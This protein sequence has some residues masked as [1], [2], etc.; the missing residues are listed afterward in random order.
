MRTAAALSLIVLGSCCLAA[1]KAQA[2]ETERVVLV[3]IDGLRYSEGL[4]DAA[5]EYTPKMHDLAQQGSIVEP[6]RNDGY[7]WTSRAIPAIWC[8]AWT[9]VLPFDDPACGGQENSYSELPTG[10]EYFRKQLNE[11]AMSC[12]YV[13]KDVGCPWRA[14]FHP[15]Y[16]PDWWPLYDS[17]GSDDLDVW[18]ETLNVLT[19]YS[20]KFLLVYLAEVDHAG[21]SGNWQTYV[22]AIAT[23]DSI[24][25]MIWTSI[26]Q[27]PDYAGKT[28]MIVSN[29]HGR[30]DWSFAG[31][32]DGCEGCRE[33]Q[34]LALGPDI[35]QGFVSN[36]PRTLCDITPTLGALMGFS[37]EYAT[38]SAM[39]EILDETGVA[40]LPQGERLDLRAW[41]NPFRER[42]QLSFNLARGGELRLEAFDVSGRRVAEVFGGSLPAGEKQLTW[43]PQRSGSELAAGL[44]FLRLQAQDAVE[45]RPVL[46]LR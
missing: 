16:G 33:I 35:K 20:P 12:I 14:S 45:S 31:H 18:H 29:D 4:G 9:E 11:P 22:N 17:G 7:T 39:E 34:L 38:G 6:F 27:L 42:T 30:H 37:T 41:P 23:A 8:G 43:E 5:Q 28:T 46:L 40:D 10:F 44:Y 19:A 1:C 2:L 21:H 3:I 13:L 26:G 32:G 24:V 25:D 15:D 36:T